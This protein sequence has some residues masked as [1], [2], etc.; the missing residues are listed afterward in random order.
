MLGFVAWILM[1][2]LDGCQS[3]PQSNSSLSAN[4]RDRLGDYE[5]GEIPFPNQE[6]RLQGR[7]VGVAKNL[8]TEQVFREV[9]N[10][11]EAALKSAIA[12]CRLFAFQEAGCVGI[13]TYSSILLPTSYGEGF[14]SWNC[15]AETNPIAGDPLF[16]RAWMG[17]GKTQKEA[18]NAALRNCTNLS[19]SECR[20]VRCFNEDYDKIP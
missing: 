5:Q 16:S 18:E 15:F 2:H 13:R 12:L 17:A 1:G 14:G 10:T 7:Y 3:K 20:T 11:R 4:N 9:A 8:Y 6:V 19:G